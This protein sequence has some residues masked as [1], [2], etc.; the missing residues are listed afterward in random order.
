MDT[1]FCVNEE[2]GLLE[3]EAHQ[4]LQSEMSQMEMYIEVL[5]KIVESI[6]NRQ[7]KPRTTLS[8]RTPETNKSMV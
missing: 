5:H 7:S 8:R 6:R 1:T 3:G 4:H 2:S